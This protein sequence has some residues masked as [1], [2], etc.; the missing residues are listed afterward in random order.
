M[1]TPQEKLN[2]LLANWTPTDIQEHWDEFTTCQPMMH[3]A[4]R[5]E[6]VAYITRCEVCR[7]LLWLTWKRFDRH[8]IEEHR[9]STRCDCDEM[10]EEMLNQDL[11]GMWDESDF[12]GEGEWAQPTHIT[13]VPNYDDRGCLNE[14][15]PEAR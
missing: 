1:P 13:D 3:Q 11:P 10:E 4:T 5:I 2:Q 8:V 14:R 7:T 15:P 9:L 12:L 6:A